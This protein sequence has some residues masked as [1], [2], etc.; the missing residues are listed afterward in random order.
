MGVGLRRGFDLG[1]RPPFRRDVPLTYRAQRDHVRVQR[2]AVPGLGPRA[3][4]KL[5]DLLQVPTPAPRPSAAGKHRK[6]N[7]PPAAEH[8]PLADDLPSPLPG[9]CLCDLID[10]IIRGHD[11]AG[12]D[13]ASE[14]IQ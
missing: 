5:D 8:L 2:D 10:L 14:P 12:R 1:D 13:I 6:A 9:E 11:P 4:G 3:S 7:P